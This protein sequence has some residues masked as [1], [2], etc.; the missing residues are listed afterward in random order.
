MKVIII[1]DEQPAR[2]LLRNYISRCPEHECV[3]EAENGFAGL[4][5]INEYKPDLVLLDIQMPKLTGFE[6]L[7]LLNEPPFIIFTTAYDE[8][9]I[10]AFELH[11]VDYL[12]KPFSFE[13]FSKAIDKAVEQ[14]KT[15][16]PKA[17]SQTLI[18]EYQKNSGKPIERLIIKKGTQIIVIP[19]EH[20][21][22][23]EAEDD[24]VMVYAQEG[25]F[26]KEKTMKTL[27]EQLN[28]EMFVRLH[29]SFIVNIQQIKSIQQYEKESYLC[30]L[31]SGEKIKASKS[32][33]K[34]LK[35]ML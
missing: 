28:P 26:L 1:D 23:I 22:Y 21:N 9:A 14:C 3:A 5:Y 32:G 27:E 18:Q 7:E 2:E 24:Y 15:K 33:Y 17:S 20:I 4:K 12:L 10:K 13:R 29:R 19:T 8:F 31:K 34:K 25:R 11:A 35:E 30:I 16:S 6:M